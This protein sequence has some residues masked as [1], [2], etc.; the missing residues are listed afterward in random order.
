LV[1]SS[2]RSPYEAPQIASAS[3]PITRSTNSF[4]ISRNRSVSPSSTC[5]R[6]YERPSIVLSTTALLLPEFH[7]D[8]VEDDAV[9]FFNDLQ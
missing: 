2:E 4:T 7:Q 1:R 8:L 5:L 6:T 9:V 3:S